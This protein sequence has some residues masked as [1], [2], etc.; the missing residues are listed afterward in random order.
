MGRKLMFLGVLAGCHHIG[1]VSGP[2]PNSGPQDTTLPVARATTDNENSA[3]SGQARIDNRH[4][5]LG[6]MVPNDEHACGTTCTA[7][8]PPSGGSVQCDG[9]QCLPSCPTG[10]TLA[11]GKCVPTEACDPARPFKDSLPQ[12]GASGGYIVKGDFNQDGKLDLVDAGGALL[13]HVG[14][15]N[16]I[17]APPKI[18]AG[19]CFYGDLKAGDFNG[20][21]KLDLASVSSS[22]LSVLLGDGNG[23]F[24]ILLSDASITGTAT[25][26][27]DVADFDHD[28][29]LDLAIASSPHPA[30][31]LGVGDG[32]FRKGAA[33]P[34]D[35]NSW[36]LVAGDFNHDGLLDVAAADSENGG[37]LALAN[38]DGS[39]HKTV[40][41]RGGR[42]LDFAVGDFNGDEF[43]DFVCNSEAGLTVF[44]GQASGTPV[45]STTYVGSC[46]FVPFSGQTVA[47]TIVVVDW[48]GDNKADLFCAAGKSDPALLLG[49]G[50]G[51]FSPSW[52]IDVSIP[53]PLIPGDF[54]ADG[55]IDLVAGVDVLLAKEDGQ[56]VT[57]NLQVLP[58]WPSPLQAGPVWGEH[59]VLSADFDGDGRL[60]VAD[61]YSVFLNRGDGTFSEVSYQPDLTVTPDDLLAGDINGDQIV[62]L[63][64]IHLDGTT[65]V[66]LGSGDGAL[67]K[68]IS[69]LS[70]AANCYYPVVAAGDFNSDGKLDLIQEKNR[71]NDYGAPAG[72]DLEIYL[73][74][75]D[76][77][78]AK[79]ASYPLGSNVF[80]A[81]HRPP[82]L[83]D[84][85]GDHKLDT[86]LTI[87]AVGDFRV[88]EE[89]L[90]VFLG[91]GDG[92]LRELE[93]M[94]IGYHHGTLSAGDFNHDGRLDL[95][96]TDTNRTTQ[97]LLGQGDGTFLRK[98][99]L[100][101]VRAPW[102]PPLVQDINGDG[103]P[104]L[105][106]PTAFGANKVAL[107]WGTGDGTFSDGGSYLIPDLVGATLGDFDGD[108]KADLYARTGRMDT[109]TRGAI[110]LWNRSCTP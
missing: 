86:A 70:L 13:L 4:L 6:Q 88:Q 8:T 97:I 63:V 102:I 78:F 56:V 101:S 57:P 49:D 31:F 18:L 75:G 83:G 91:S 89:R 59:P 80:G 85:D 87:G 46:N 62:D 23:N 15:G 36:S 27:M 30:I 29:K 84:F 98:Q 5:C 11:Q 76:G 44:L 105:L 33:L 39:F 66:F 110:M 60:D 100:P 95:T 54:N 3:L 26:A 68:P 64:Q 14:L 71:F 41:W 81:D 94:Q 38:S 48:N 40:A 28:G 53:A 79:S 61:A 2:E 74:R 104:D 82:V 106:F 25:S 7:C 45:E 22:G 37:V 77:S 32:S 21:G 96:Q 67:G 1:S 58:G 109:Q 34:I 9:N 42:F 12:L 55:R 35:L 16:G 51:H 92:T 50:A 17:F 93:Q 72:S 52:Q 47:G 99:T 107:F 20:D 24:Q 73:G 69:R 65:T 108:G 10:S 90:R 103:H 43:P 19:C